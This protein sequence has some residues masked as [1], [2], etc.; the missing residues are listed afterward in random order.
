MRK[1]LT[2]VTFQGLANISQCNVPLQAGNVKNVAKLLK[3]S[4]NIINHFWH[5]C[6]T[7]E[8]GPMELKVHNVMS[9][10]KS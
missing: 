7:C 1:A 2:K 10:A 8:G 5:H 3:R 9:T 6:Q 4:G